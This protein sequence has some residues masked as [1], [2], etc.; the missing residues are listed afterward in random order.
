MTETIT[1]FP[2][3]RRSQPWFEASPQVQFEAEMASNSLA[4]RDQLFVEPALVAA[5]LVFALAQ[6]E[7]GARINLER[8]EMRH[9][10]DLDTERP[11]LVTTAGAEVTYFDPLLSIAVLSAGARVESMRTDAITHIEIVPA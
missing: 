8:L 4:E 10:H 9:D 11:T 2:G 7:M 6:R 5:H 1:Q 3:R